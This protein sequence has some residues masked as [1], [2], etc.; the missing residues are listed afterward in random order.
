MSKQ[1][2]LAKGHRQG[3]EKVAKKTLEVTKQ[4]TAQTKMVAK[5]LNTIKH[6][7]NKDVATSESE[8]ESETDESEDMVVEEATQ[9]RDL[10]ILDQILNNESR[11]DELPSDI[12]VEEVQVSKKKKV[13]E[14]SKHS[15]ENRK[16]SDLLI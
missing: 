8:N 7:A 13:V 6:V 5:T 14:I 4:T 11:G 16:R 2:P 12:E 3:Q 9:E 1:K 10:A 15:E